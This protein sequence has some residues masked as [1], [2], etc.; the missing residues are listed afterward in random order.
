MGEDGQPGA[1]GMYFPYDFSV[2]PGDAANTSLEA[3]PQVVAHIVLV[4][5]TG[6]TRQATGYCRYGA[7]ERRN[8]LQVPQLG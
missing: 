6:R 8:L 2:Y 5:F 4:D 1:I 7:V 3:G